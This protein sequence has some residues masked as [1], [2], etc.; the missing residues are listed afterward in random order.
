MC[1][2]LY[3][4]RACWPSR[5]VVSVIQISSAGSGASSTPSKT[6]RGTLVY[7]NGVNTGGF[8][9]QVLGLQ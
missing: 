5:K 9:G 3:G 6:I 7:G 4:G 2:G 1:S 8:P